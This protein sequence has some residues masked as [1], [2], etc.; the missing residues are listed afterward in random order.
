MVCRSWLMTSA[1]V[2]SSGWPVSKVCSAR[3]DAATSPLFRACRCSASWCLRVQPVCP[4]YMLGHPLQGMESCSTPIR[5]PSTCQP[6]LASL[7]VWWRRPQVHLSLF[8]DG[9][10]PAGCWWRPTPPTITEPPVL[11]YRLHECSAPLGGHRSWSQCPASCPVVPF[12]SPCRSSTPGGQQFQHCDL[13]YNIPHPQ[14]GTLAYLLMD[15]SHR[16]CPTPHRWCQFPLPFQ[17]FDGPG[18]P[19]LISGNQAIHLHS[20]PG[21]GVLAEQ[22]EEGGGPGSIFIVICLVLKVR[23]KLFIHC[24]SILD[25]VY[26]LP[27]QN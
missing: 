20:I 14:P 4:M 16:R 26:Q 7:P 21:K 23:L 27:G 13:W 18:M 11:C 9:N 3:V 6:Q 17:S 8:V 12:L 2:R 15:F 10:G 5:E 22:P 19:P 1:L 25:N 24:S